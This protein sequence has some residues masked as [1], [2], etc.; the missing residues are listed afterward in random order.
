MEQRLTLVTLGVSDLPKARAFYEEKFGWTPLPASSEGIVFFQLNSVQLALFPAHALAEDAQVGADGSGFKKFTLAHN[1][2]SEKEVDNLVSSL[3]SRGV[4]VVK[5]PQK[6]F[7]GGY[8]AYVADL[9]DN[10]WEIAYN[11][12]L[13]PD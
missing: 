2:S 10:L 7:W 8:S 4:V 5:R 12:Y 6:V 1:V 11:P 13:L 3:E 9:D